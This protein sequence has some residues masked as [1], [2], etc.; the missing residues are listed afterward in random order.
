MDFSASSTTAVYSYHIVHPAFAFPT[1]LR[2]TGPCLISKK[3]RSNACSY[4]ATAARTPPTS[5]SRRALLTN[6]AAIAVALALPTS[7]YARKEGDDVFSLP[8][9]PYAYNGLEPY[10]SEQ[11]MKAHHDAHFATY[12]KKLNTALNKLGSV[13]SEVKDDESLK[14]LLSRLDTIS[15]QELRTLLRNNGGGYLNHKH[16][17]AQMKPNAKPLQNG[18]LLRDIEA[19]FG[20]FK[21]FSTKFLATSTGLF[22]SGFVWL[23]K[24]SKDGLLR[25]SKYPNQDNPAMDSSPNTPLLACDCWE[26]SWYYQYGPKKADYISAWWNVI[27]WQYVNNLYSA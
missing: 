6:T 7:T 18:P 13:A 26:H 10:I 9:L 19:Q 23:V 1:P 8:E 15:D 17:F 25:I 21:N 20:S 12:V 24:D 16:F 5:L 11:I 22:G 27:D 2:A 4:V 14:S 3:S